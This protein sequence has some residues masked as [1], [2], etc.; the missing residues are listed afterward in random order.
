MS[1]L[2]NSKHLGVSERQANVVVLPATVKTQAF[3]A[4]S[5]NIQ[6][7]SAGNLGAYA[8]NQAILLQADQNC[9]VLPVA[10]S[11]GT[12]S[13]STGWLLKQNELYRF[14]INPGFEYLAV[15]RAS[16]D[17]TLKIGVGSP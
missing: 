7:T 8:K 12:V 10:S 16:A 2:N 4:T 3:T 5:A 14:F 6:L 13:S 9:Y 15:I 1:G 17:G 11:S